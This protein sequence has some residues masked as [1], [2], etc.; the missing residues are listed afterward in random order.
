MDSTT[1]LTK[2]SDT[3]TTTA[4]IIWLSG[5]TLG[6]TYTVTNRIFTVGNRQEDRSL[7]IIVRDR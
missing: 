6:S 2:I 1:G 5:G 4:A 7:I 3:S